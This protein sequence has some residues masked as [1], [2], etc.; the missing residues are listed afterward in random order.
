MLIPPRLSVVKNIGSQIGIETDI[1]YSINYTAIFIVL[2]WTFIFISSAYKLL[3][4]EIYSIFVTMNYVKVILLICLLLCIGSKT[5]AQNI[6]VDP[7]VTPDVLVKNILINSSC[8]SIDNVSASGNPLAGQQSYGSFTGG[9]NFPFSTGLVLATSASKNAEGP[10]NQATSIGVKV[11]SWN[12]DPDLNTALGTS[13]STHAT[14]L[15]FD[16]I[17]STNSISFNYFFASNEYQSFYPVLIQT[18]LLS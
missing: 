17:P 4:I 13:T 9:S 10:Y 15:E 8:L 2:A 14:V 3:K 11:F 6:S 12:G 18:D 16:F 7:T 1:D 5:S